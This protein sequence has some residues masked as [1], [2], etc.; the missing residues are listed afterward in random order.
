MTSTRT[1]VPAQAVF[2]SD[3]LDPGL[4]VA[5]EWC[6]YLGC[7]VVCIRSSRVS[8]VMAMDVLYADLTLTL[9]TDGHLGISARSIRWQRCKTSLLD[10]GIPTR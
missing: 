9:T 2:R 10:M 8:Q 3:I 1:I 7:N 4:D 6:Y 5:A